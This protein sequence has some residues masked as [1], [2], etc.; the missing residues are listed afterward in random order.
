MLGERVTQTVNG[1]VVA[2]GEVREWRPGSNLLKISKINGKFRSD[3]HIV[4]KVSK[5]TATIK[6]T[7]VSL[8][9]AD[10]RPYS[11]NTGDFRSDRGR[12]GVSNQRLIDSF[13]YQD[14]SYVVKSRTSI[15]SWRELVKETTHPAGFKLFGE[16]IIDPIVEDGIT[17]P[18]KMPKASHFS[19]IQLSD[20]VSI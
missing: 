18:E 2:F 11:D 14:Y 7:Y 16:V 3:V 8:F 5:I 20:K 13:F 4:S 17:M 19:I 1:T 15:D 9:N 10:L 6:N 12:L